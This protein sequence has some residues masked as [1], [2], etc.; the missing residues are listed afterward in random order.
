MLF[1]WSGIRNCT[2]NRE[3]SNVFLE[4]QLTAKRLQ[5]QIKW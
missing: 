4:K 1:K 2:K 3:V 5:H